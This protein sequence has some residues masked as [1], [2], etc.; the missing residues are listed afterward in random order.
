VAKR[1]IAVVI[2]GVFNVG[3]KGIADA[4][5]FAQAKSKTSKWG[6]AEIVY[7]THAEL[8]N[9]TWQLDKKR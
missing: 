4:R 2:D 8:W 3:F 6:A 7:V 1:E 9:G 5:K